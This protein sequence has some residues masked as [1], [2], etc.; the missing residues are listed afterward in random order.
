M[1]LALA[2]AMALALAL[3]MALALAVGF[4][5]WSRNWFRVVGA[6]QRQG[7]AD[8]VALGTRVMGTVGLAEQHFQG[9]VD[10]HRS[11]GRDIAKITTFIIFNQA[12]AL[13]AAP[14]RFILPTFSVP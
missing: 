6:A 1:A 2:L 14:T 12:V 3:A 11:F 7:L 4:T 13:S 8:R 5:G 9:L 10:A